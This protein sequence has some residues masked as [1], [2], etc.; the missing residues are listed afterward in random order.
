MSGSAIRVPTEAELEAATTAF[1]LDWGGVDET[2]YRLCAEHPDHSDRRWATAKVA[3]IGRAY[4][5]GL[6]RRV[7]PAPGQ[8]AIAV[9]ADYFEQ[10]AGDVDAIL[11]GLASIAEPLS[12]VDMRTIVA[13]HGRFTHLLVGVT[14]DKKTPRSFA[15]K[16]LHFHCPVVPIYD[17]YCSRSLTRRVRWSESAKPFE[18]PAGADADYFWFCVRFMRLYAACRR[19]G[20]EATVKDLDALL[21]Q[22]PTGAAV[23]SPNVSRPPFVDDRYRA[24][25]EFGTTYTIDELWTQPDE[26]LT[27]WREILNEYGLSFDGY[28]YAQAVWDRECPDVAND[29]WER[30]RRDGRFASS[31]AEL[32]CALFFT[33]RC[34]RNN[35][36]SPG[37]RPGPELE[38][39]VHELYAAIGEAWR[40]ERGEHQ[41]VV[42]EDAPSASIVCGVDGCPGGWVV[43]WYDLGSGR[44]WWEVVPE[45]AAIANASPSPGVIG[46]DVPI[47]LVETGPRECDTLVRQ[48]LGSKR[49]ASVFP[50]PIRP[51]LAAHDHAEASAT[52][53][54]VEGKGMSVQSWGIAPKIRE[55]DEAL[56]DD[57]ELRG[58]IREVHPELCFHVMNR[59]RPLTDSKKKPVGKR[60]R[61]ALLRA[62]F[63]DVVLEALASKPRG[64]ASD[65][66]LDAFA[67]VWTARR[68]ARD[69]AKT[70]PANP[71]RDRYDLPMRMIV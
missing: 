61:V 25:A 58:R 64:C 46:I 24:R 10:H 29:V 52:R 26:S 41:Q 15:S 38:R 43:V 50:A 22:V 65:D 45:L 35:E 20:V 66:L 56:R 69:E 31:F 49:G 7:T 11:G 16:Y 13:V 17:D 30:R 57:H 40:S 1:E 39:E 23:S 60:E 5:A 28:A 47:G 55:V 8:Q 51:V 54:A 32:R 18:L 6:E 9:I 27:N 70:I 62:Q 2:L 34:V 21:W 59:E 44:M 71:P 33:Q 3:L 37:W 36:Q 12:V 19:E 48:A 67:A 42:A 68:V 14:T 63:G 53:R 4:S